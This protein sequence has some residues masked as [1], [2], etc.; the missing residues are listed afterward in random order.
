MSLMSKDFNGGA[1]LGLK[2]IVG[3][4]SCVIGLGVVYFAF[5]VGNKPI[6]QNATVNIKPAAEEGRRHKP[7]RA[8]NM[9]LGDMVFFA[10]DLGFTVKTPKDVPYDDGGKIAIRIENQLQQL[11]EFYRQ[12]SVKNSSLVGGMMLQLNIGPAGDVLQVK[13]VSSLIADTDF[14]KAVVAAAAKWSFADIVS[15]PLTISCPL[16]FVREGMDITTLVQWEKS[17]GHFTDKTTSTRPTVIAT[18]PAKAVA[19]A[20]TA[21]SPGKPGGISTNK[22]APTTNAKT[23]AKLFQIKYPTSLRKDPN[24]SSNSLVTFTIG[25][26]V[27]LINH[28]GDW[29]E[30]K[31]TDNR[32][33]G[34]IRK[35]FVA[36]ITVA[37][38]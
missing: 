25:T 18:Q 37:R 38:N 2:G 24:F 30:V 4:A 11:R 33:S 23:D 28:R 19:T 21:G 29:L 20:S 12:E 16:L 36:P 6:K 10:H 8:M 31:T 35:E 17:L 34:F 22:V 26:K 7:V 13:D 5:G 14:R 15:E 9:A 1:R 32:F 3:I 27:A